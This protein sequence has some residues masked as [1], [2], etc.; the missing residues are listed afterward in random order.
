[1][2]VPNGAPPPSTPPHMYTPQA[3]GAAGGELFG[4]DDYLIDTT[5]RSAQFTCIFLATKVV[6]Q[7]GDR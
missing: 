6:D 1:M 5:L 3:C 2:T 4:D 7:V